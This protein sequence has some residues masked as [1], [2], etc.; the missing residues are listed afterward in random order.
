MTT[1]I[2][3]SLPL[4]NGSHCS[5]HAIL[6]RNPV[7]TITLHLLPD[8]MVANRCPHSV[9]LLTRAP[10]N[11]DEGGVARE[12]VSV[13]NSNHVGLLPESKVQ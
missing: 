1:S 4:N 6:E 11:G 2:K 12:V 3:V 7:N 8:V 5:L 13:L 10:D 9:Q